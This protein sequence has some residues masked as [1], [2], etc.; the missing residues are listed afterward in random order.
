MKQLNIYMKRGGF[1]IIREPLRGWVSVL[2][3][4]FKM[5]EYRKINSTEKVLPSV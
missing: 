3:H 1:G 4:V 5:K 2:R